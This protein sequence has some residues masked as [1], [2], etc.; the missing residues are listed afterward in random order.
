MFILRRAGRRL[1]DC[2][3]HGD[4]DG[5]LKVLRE[6]SNA[7]HK[8]GS[9]W[10]VARRLVVALTLPQHLFSGQPSLSSYPL[11]P[12]PASASFLSIYHFTKHPGPP[13]YLSCLT[14]RTVKEL[15]HLIELVLLHHPSS[16]HPCYGYY[17]PCYTWFPG[18]SRRNDLSR[19]RYLLCTVFEKHLLPQGF[20][21]P[22]EHRW[23][24]RFWY[25]WLL[26]TARIQ[27]NN[28][29]KS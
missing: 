11:K 1:C 13:F 23:K 16:N 3:W 9:Q 2:D 26:P 20:T 19:P 21:Q 6:V 5:K 29:F 17:S 14:L 10:R 7:A 15:P 4:C 28:M 22:G 27:R 24:Y 18:H 8:A 25:F 12:L